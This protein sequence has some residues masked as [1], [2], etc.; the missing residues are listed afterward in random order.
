M[1]GL[2][3]NCKPGLIRLMTKHKKE[4]KKRRERKGQTKKGREEKG[5]KK[6]KKAEKTI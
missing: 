6:R 5:H 4:R 1:H 3:R 2:E